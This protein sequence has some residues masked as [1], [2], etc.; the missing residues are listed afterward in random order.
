MIEK[1]AAET[2]MLI[3]GGMGE[4]DESSE[5]A[6]ALMAKIRAAH[7]REGGGPVFLG[8][9]CLGVISHPGKYDRNNFV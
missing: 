7:E 8:A 4:T 5:R 3:A 2:V 9:N 1:N 6:S